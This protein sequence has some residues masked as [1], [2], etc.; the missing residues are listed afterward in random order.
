[1]S[2]TDATTPVPPETAMLDAAHWWLPR[3]SGCG[4]WS[5]PQRACSAALSSAHPSR[6]WR[7]ARR[8]APPSGCAAGASGHWRSSPSRCAW[9]DMPRRAWAVDAWVTLLSRGGDL[10]DIAG[11]PTNPRRIRRGA[12][13]PRILSPSQIA[14]HAM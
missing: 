3:S 13:R 14:G 6:H 12:V 1:M 10:V 5:G 9:W 7:S 8:W 2:V 11:S 4:P